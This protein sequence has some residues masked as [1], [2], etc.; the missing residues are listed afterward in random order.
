MPPCVCKL[1]V[2]HGMSS[3]GSARP[4]P[5]PTPA[6]RLGQIT[7]C[8][9]PRGTNLKCGVPATKLVLC[10]SFWTC[11]G[12]PLPEQNQASKQHAMKLCIFAQLFK[13]LKHGEETDSAGSEFQWGVRVPYVC[14]MTGVSMDVPQGKREYEAGRGKKRRESGHRQSKENGK[15][16]GDDSRERMAEETRR[17]KGNKNTQ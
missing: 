8:F 6:A 7:R 1:R 11:T 15:C 5:P 13:T 4:P 9:T 10:A 12:L 14:S 17:A 3:L 16:S 2:L